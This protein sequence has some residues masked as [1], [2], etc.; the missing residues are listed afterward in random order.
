MV[1]NVAATEQRERD[2]EDIRKGHQLL[3][4]QVLRIG[5]YVGIFEVNS[6]SPFPDEKLARIGIV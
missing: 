1:H 3:A 2:Y 6:E 4:L 5:K